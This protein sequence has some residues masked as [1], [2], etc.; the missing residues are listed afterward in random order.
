MA[1]C[2]SSSWSPTSAG[3]FDDDDIVAAY[4]AFIGCGIGLGKLQVGLEYKFVQSDDTKDNF[5]VEGS[6]VSLFAMLPF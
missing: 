5:A 3:N 2:P 4:Q 1:A 6:T